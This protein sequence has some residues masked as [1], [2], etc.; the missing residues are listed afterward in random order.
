MEAYNNLKSWFRLN[1]GH[2]DFDL[3][4]YYIDEENLK[5][6]F[7]I[8]YR[9]N[10]TRITRVSLENIFDFTSYCPELKKLIFDALLQSYGYRLDN[11]FTPIK[12]IKEFE[13]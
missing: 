1:Y 3:S 4:P 9:N 5:P 12:K 7:G 2:L 11:N 6:Y 10:K 8:L 13:L